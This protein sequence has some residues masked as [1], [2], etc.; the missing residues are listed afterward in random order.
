MSDMFFLFAIA[1]SSQSSIE[2]SMH[3]HSFS[4]T[5]SVEMLTTQTVLEQLLL[6]SP[7]TAVCALPHSLAAEMAEQAVVTPLIADTGLQG[8]GC[9]K[10]SFTKEEGWS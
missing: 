5:Y 6:M 1:L 3:K 8:S 2:V 7:D 4:R 10:R 9:L